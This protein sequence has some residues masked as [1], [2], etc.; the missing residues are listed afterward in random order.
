MKTKLIVAVAASLMVAG[1]ATAP[2]VEN[3]AK[4]SDP[5]AK[6]AAYAKLQAEAP[7]PIEGS[8]G[9]YMSPFTSDGVTAEWV[10]KSMK[11]EASGKIGQAAGT[12]AAEHLLSN[13]PFAGMFAGDASKKLAR[14]MAL[15]GIGGEEFLKS[16]SDLSFDSL[17]DMAK[18]MYAFHS[19]HEEYAKIVKAT[20]AIYPDFAKAYAKF[21][22]P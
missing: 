12:I 6:E 7:K 19:S 4:I 16:S 1:C 2:S 5:V 22:Q 10:T 17:D 8:S 3:V 11:V 20:I 13:V 21:P 15:K 14:A 9:K 18:Y